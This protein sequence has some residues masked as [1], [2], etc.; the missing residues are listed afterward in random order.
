LRLMARPKLDMVVEVDDLKSSEGIET[1]SKCI[2]S[3]M[4][5]TF[6]SKV[7]IL[8][9]VALEFDLYLVSSKST[10]DPDWEEWRNSLKMTV[11]GHTFAG[12]AGFGADNQSAHKHFCRFLGLEEKQEANWFG[13]RAMQHGKDI[14][15]VV[16]RHLEVIPLHMDE[17]VYANESLVYELVLEKTHGFPLPLCITPDILAEKAVYEI[18]C[19]YYN[20]DKFDDPHLF[21]LDV[22]NRNKEKYGIKINPSWWLQAA[23]YAYITGK[24]FFSLILCYYVTRTD[25]Y[26]LSY[27][28]FELGNR[29]R[30]YIRSELRH[31]AASAEMFSADPQRLLG[32][33]TKKYKPCYTDKSILLSTIASSL[34]FSENTPT[35]EWHIDGTIGIFPNP[36]SIIDCS[37]YCETLT[38][39]LITEIN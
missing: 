34:Y 7:K 28:H 32:K 37:L 20:A 18:K 24:R 9:R 33:G 11:G 39:T 14:E 13:K 23:L 2:G 19:P 15:L 17:K 22:E 31:I 27:W 16:K 21:R 25:M 12:L 29:E 36:T 6:K 30:E 8:N 26:T 10:E 35:F 3:A 5:K 4:K 1:P 38:N